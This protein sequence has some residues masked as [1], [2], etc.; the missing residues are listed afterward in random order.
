MLLDRN[1]L[2]H[3][4]F[5]TCLKKIK[6]IE[7]VIVLKDS[8]NISSQKR[9][10]LPNLLPFQVNWDIDN[11]GLTKQNGKQANACMI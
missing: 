5:K 6:V 2:I 8:W 1:V 7:M 4:I 3:I 11:H 9:E 10:W